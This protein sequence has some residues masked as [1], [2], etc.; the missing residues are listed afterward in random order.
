MLC[1][2]LP[3]FPSLPP[4]LRCLCRTPELIAPALPHQPYATAVGMRLQ[5][6][7]AVQ[8][9]PPKTARKTSCG[10]RLLLLCPLFGDD[11]IR[12]SYEPVGTVRRRLCGHRQGDCPPRMSK[13]FREVRR[14]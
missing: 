13:G 11:S 3:F 14:V 4:S 1:L 6:H 12:A 9:A 10:R 5:I 8:T 7:W 2:P